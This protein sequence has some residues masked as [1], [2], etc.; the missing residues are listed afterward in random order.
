MVTV[1]VVLNVL[2]IAWLV[3]LSTRSFRQRVLDSVKEEIKTL[4]LQMDKAVELNVSRV[5]KAVGDLKKILASAEKLK[6]EMEEMVNRAELLKDLWN[7]DK[8]KA[9]YFLWRT[10]ESA[11]SISKKL[12]IPYAE[13]TVLVRMFKNFDRGG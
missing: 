4:I 9:A 8:I 3:Y 2:I 13:A 6:G 7:D 11:S 12:S 1:L 5:E 10:G